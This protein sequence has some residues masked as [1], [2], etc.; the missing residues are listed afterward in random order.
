MQRV[1]A[2]DL[3]CRKFGGNPAATKRI[4]KTVL[5]GKDVSD[6]AQAAGGGATA[7]TSPVAT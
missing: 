4:L 3:Q 2:H 6:L 5:G 1:L 7:T